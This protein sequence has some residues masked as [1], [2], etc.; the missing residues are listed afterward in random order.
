MSYLYF[1]DDELEILYQAINN[2]QICFHPTYAPEGNFTVK[3]SFELQ[4]GDKDITVIADKNLVSPICEV[5]KNGTLSDK[6]RLQKV[7][8]FVT[9]TKYLNARLTCGIGLLENDTAGLS[10]ATGEE[11]RL[12]FLH[13]VDN[14]PAVI[15]KDIAF[16][17]RDTVPEVFLYN[18]TVTKNQSYNLEDHLLLLSNE[19]AIAKIVEFIRT[20]SI[21]PIDKFISFMNWYTDHLDIAESIMVYAAMV[22]ASIQNVSPPKKAQS[23]SFDEVQKGVKNQAWDITSITTRSLLYYNETQ[24][25]CNMFATDDITQKIIIVNV[26]PPGQCAEAI[27]AIFTTK[28]HRKKIKELAEKKLG[29]ARVRPFRN[30]NEDEKISIVKRLLDREYEN[31]RKMCIDN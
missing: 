20:P 4:S 14:I 28:A 1:E 21:Q 24:E 19:A 29:A 3:A 18:G 6:H 27:G 5:A 11:N 12:Q 9:W 7:A 23:K 10:T 30:M 15:W 31:L 17:Y 22:F 26:L 16:G 13:G 2:Q 25:S 8:L